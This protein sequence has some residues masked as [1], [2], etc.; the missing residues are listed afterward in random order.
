M[1]VFYS[2]NGGFKT[3]NNSKKWHYFN[4]KGR[5]IPGP[6]SFVSWS[7]FCP[8]HH[9]TPDNNGTEESPQ[10]GLNRPAIAAL[11]GR[12]FGLRNS[13]NAFRFLWCLARPATRRTV[14]RYQLRRVPKRV[15][16]SRVTI[17]EVTLP[18]QSCPS[19]QVASRRQ[20]NASRIAQ[21]S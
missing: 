15:D 16:Q 12:H 5:S 6:F 17:G 9:C 13:L 18:D 4:K 19:G 7:S 1:L 2:L 10:A 3:A 8:S 21:S 20:G 11:E 14:S